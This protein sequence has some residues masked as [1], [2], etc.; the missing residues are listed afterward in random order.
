MN[1]AAMV[2]KKMRDYT[3]P[4]E[5]L[6]KSSAFAGYLATLLSIPCRSIRKKVPTIRM[7]AIPEDPNGVGATDGRTI[8]LNPLS[9][10]ISSASSRAVKARLLLGVLTHEFGHVRFT[11]RAGSFAAQQAIVNNKWYPELPKELDDDCSE[12]AEDVHELIEKN[13]E[14]IGNVLKLWHDIYNI[15]EDC[16]IEESL[17]RVMS[18]VL[19]DGLNTFRVYQHDSAMSLADMLRG[20]DDGKFMMYDVVT[21]LLLSYGKFG[22]MKC[23]RKNPSERDSEP[24][25]WI[26][27]ARRYVDQILYSSSTP[28]RLT[29]VNLTFLTLWPIIKEKLLSMPIDD[30]SSLGS[31]AAGDMRS[32]GMDTKGAKGTPRPVAVSKKED[33]G[34]S[35]SRK[36]RSEIAKEL[37]DSPSEEDEDKESTGPSDEDDEGSDDEASKASDEGS[38]DEASEASDEGSDDEA[39]EASD[40]GSHDERDED[41]SD[42]VAELPDDI[43][44]TTS[45]DVDETFSDTEISA[46]MSRIERDMKE[47]KAVAEVNEELTSELRAEASEMDYGAIHRGISTDIQRV[48]NVSEHAIS[49]YET[50]MGEIEKIADIM[51]RRVKPHL[52]KSDGD[53]AMNMSGFFSGSRFDATRLVYNDYRVFK[54]AATPLPDNKIAVSILVDESAS[55][56]GTRIEMARAAAIALYGFC[57]RCELAC[58]VIGHTAPFSS[59]NLELSIYADFDTPDK[60]DKYRLL[61]ISAKQDNRDGAAIL[62]AGEHLLKRQEKTKLLFIIS[63]GAPCARGYHGLSAEK[64]MTNI[65]HELTRRGVKIFAAAI[66]DD[67]KAI[68]RI[69]GSGFL[70]ISALETLPEQMLALVKRY[71]H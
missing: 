49:T 63:D 8:W 17:Y 66:G 68:H 22:T 24:V 32:S 38:D 48:V 28:R 37:F 43:G 26:R 67:R 41:C 18:G 7:G 69:F 3:I 70:D 16:Y 20:L 54:N 59:G 6:F 33:T 9:P 12:A 5:E 40:R 25:K 29:G 34:K 42:G 64:D 51:A 21:S 55:M 10:F 52:R 71:I 15:L 4:D 2:A 31:E 44:G 57:E 11:D 53:F 30:D 62:F 58:S 56:W 45:S 35:G 39:S 36:M 27:Y 50:T 19:L 1:S 14:Y 60:K 13:P 23:D 47:E 61:N 46:V 65:A